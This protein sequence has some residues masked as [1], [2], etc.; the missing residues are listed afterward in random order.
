M[1]MA[2]E[3]DSPLAED[4]AGIFQK[5]VVLKIISGKNK[6]Y[7]PNKTSHSRP[8]MTRNLQPKY[9]GSPLWSS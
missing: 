8:K 4:I 3:F 6:L 1:V 7:G 5:F 2:P 9:Y